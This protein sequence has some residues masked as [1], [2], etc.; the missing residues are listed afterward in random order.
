M[1]GP[2]RGGGLPDR[3]L[4]HPDRIPHRDEEHRLPDGSAA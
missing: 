1:E 4:D 2:G 3:P